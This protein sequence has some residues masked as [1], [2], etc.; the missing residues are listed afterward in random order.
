M[1]SI[2]GKYLLFAS[3][4]YVLENFKLNEVNHG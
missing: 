1:Y 3:I 4:I 2:Y